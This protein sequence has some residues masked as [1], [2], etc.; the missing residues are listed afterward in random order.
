M[1]PARLR[2]SREPA[3]RSV[4][5]ETRLA[6][7]IAPRAL[8]VS[9]ME[10]EMNLPVQAELIA[11]FKARD[12]AL[13]ARLYADDA[14]F[15]TPGRKP[16]A[17]RNAV[18]EVVAEDLKDPGF[19]LNLLGQATGLA[20]SG[21]LAY[22]RGTFEASFTDPQTKQVQ[23]VGGTYLQIFRKREDGSWEI[24]EDVSSPG[25]LAVEA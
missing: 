13:I 8:H 24:L 6:T 16:I 17:G 11:A 7:L 1:R 18:A 10:K 19:S 20:A 12:P 21:D 22:A 2:L 25:P 3:G 14:T 23:S 5:D 4:A 9:L 15:V